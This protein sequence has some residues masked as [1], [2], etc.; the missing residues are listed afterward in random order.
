MLRL[1]IA[2][3]TIGYEVDN[4]P[5]VGLLSALVIVIESQSSWGVSQWTY[6][7]RSVLAQSL[8]A[9]A[10]AQL[11]RL[12]H[13][14]TMVPWRQLVPREEVIGQI[15]RVAVLCAGGLFPYQ[16]RFSDER[17]HAFPQGILCSAVAYMLMAGFCELAVH[18][19]RRAADKDNRE[20][21]HFAQKQEYNL[22]RLAL[23]VWL[24]MAVDLAVWEFQDLLWTEI[25]FGTLLLGCA[26]S[27]CMDAVV[28]RMHAVSS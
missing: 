15:L 11:L 4:L 14:R 22:L 7:W 20:T 3:L 23:V 26:A 9:A 2:L 24:V 21:R 1:L 19:S 12:A 13:E 27:K 25:V 17:D 6:G 28:V 16:W 18:N 10:L 5:T 8:V